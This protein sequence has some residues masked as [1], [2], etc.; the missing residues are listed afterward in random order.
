MTNT[1][2]RFGNRQ[3]FD[4]DIIISA[5]PS[6]GN[7]DEDCIPRLKEF[8]RICTKHNPVNMGN[9][10]H[11]A[12]APEH[13]LKPS[14][15]WKRKAEFRWTEVIDGVFRPGTVSAVFS[16]QADAEACLKDIIEADFGLSVNIST[17]IANAKLVAE[18]SGL[19]RHSVEYALEINDPHKLLPDSQV[20][21]LSTMCGHGLVSN[22]LAKKMIEMVREGRR[23][24]EDAA[25]TLTRFCSCGIFNPERAKC[26]F[27]DSIKDENA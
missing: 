7:N 9:G 15:H 19:K 21:S 17:S 23:T 16:N 26:I 27:N 5:I 1:L 22:N 6:I 13:D 18:K 8:L 14:A 24:P 2:H 4:N 10:I 25:N 20:L 3:S 12:L 11:C